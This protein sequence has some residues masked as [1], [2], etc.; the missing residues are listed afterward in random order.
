MKRC[1]AFL[2]EIF[3]GFDLRNITDNCIH[4]IAICFNLYPSLSLY[5]FLSI[6]L[7][8]FLQLV[9]KNREN[10]LHA[11]ACIFCIWC[12]TF[13]I[14]IKHFHVAKSLST[15]LHALSLS[16]SSR[17][18]RLFLFCVPA[19]VHLSVGL[20]IVNMRAN[21]CKASCNLDLWFARN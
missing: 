20:C 11:L 13:L 5:L 6:C 2:R 21:S 14:A 3:R 19:Y 12:I 4:V 1:P 9:I 18:T 17:T 10:L 8:P 16:L 15:V 7:Y